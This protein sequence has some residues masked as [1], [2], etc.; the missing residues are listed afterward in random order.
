[1]HKHRVLAG[2]FEV[3]AVLILM[4]FTLFLLVNL[5]NMI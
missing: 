3:S 1:M 5:N 2:N 4:I